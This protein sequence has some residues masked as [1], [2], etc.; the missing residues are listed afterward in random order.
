[1]N[2][3]FFEYDVV[4]SIRSLGENVPSGTSGPVLIVF[5]SILPHY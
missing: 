3:K 1:M 4:R 2:A 5:A